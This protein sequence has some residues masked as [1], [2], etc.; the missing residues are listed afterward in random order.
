MGSAN[1]ATIRPPSGRAAEQPPALGHQPGA[2]L[3]AEHPGHACRGVLA[4]AVTE[5]HVGLDAPRLPQARQA[6]LD[7]EDRGLGK[8]GVPQRFSGLAAGFTIVGEQ[9]LE[10]RLRQHV[11]HRVRAT[12]DRFGENRF[13]VEQLSRHAG[14]L[15]TLP[16]EQ[17][18]R[19][20][21]V[22]TLATG[23]AV[24]QAVLGQF[25]QAGTGI[26]HRINHEGCT[27]FEVRTAHTRGE[28]QIGEVDIGVRAQPGLVA[29]RQG[30]Q[31]FR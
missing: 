28:A 2:V 13:G 4:D 6:H 15:A 5:H 10:Q 8:R 22:R 26:G 7:C 29:L 24:S 3:E 19:H 1:T 12:G 14:V 18:R 27:V 23:D 17:P 25:G 30:R 21:V 16:G 20:R 31:C 9:H 11:L